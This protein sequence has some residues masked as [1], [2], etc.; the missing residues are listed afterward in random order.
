MQLV[1]AIT[2]A[3]WMLLQALFIRAPL[4]VARCIWH[5]LKLIFW[6]AYYTS[7]AIVIG[8]A[9]F[10]YA[11]PDAWLWYAPLLF[12]YT[13]AFIT[14]VR[15]RR[16][17]DERQPTFED[18]DG[19]VLCKNCRHHYTYNQNYYYCRHPQYRIKHTDTGTGR[20]TYS[21]KYYFPEICGKPFDEDSCCDYHVTRVKN[22]N[23]DC[24]DFEAGRSDHHN[25]PWWETVCIFVDDSV[26]P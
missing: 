5:V 10:V 26:L 12:V 21:Y 15:L 7:P 23:L 18:A 24:P 9:Y 19:R 4:F 1:T 16:T 13:V 6:A 8:L 11:S 14:V 20:V 3:T 22:R 25:K 17:N 2:D